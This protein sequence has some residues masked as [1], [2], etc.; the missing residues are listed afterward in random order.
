[1][2]VI[3]PNPSPPVERDG[4]NLKPDARRY[5]DI[6]PL[7]WA[8]EII[9]G[10]P[11]G[12]MPVY[13]VIPYKLRDT[14]A[15]KQRLA[16]E[17]SASSQFMLLKEEAALGVGG[18]G[19]VIRARHVPSGEIVAAKVMTAESAKALVSARPPSC[20]SPTIRFCIS[21]CPVTIFAACAA[22]GGADGEPPPP[23]HRAAPRPR[24]SR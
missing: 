22:R 17:P 23:E 19:T 5:L 6:A 3:T 24:G 13:N 1:M 14:P 2:E 4:I 16:S 8:R 11:V 15:R 9:E 21:T 12:K 7:A 20:P 18:Y 10:A